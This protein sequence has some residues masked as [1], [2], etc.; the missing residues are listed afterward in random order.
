MACL[1]YVI[2]VPD[3]SQFIRAQEQD[4]I[5]SL[6]EIILEIEYFL[7]LWISVLNS[8][9]YTYTV[10]RFNYLLYYIKLSS[11]TSV[12]VIWFISNIYWQEGTGG[13]MVM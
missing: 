8:N 5:E 9:A 7:I 10:C 11:T 6:S 3:I 13:D 4:Q 12:F 1:I 2:T